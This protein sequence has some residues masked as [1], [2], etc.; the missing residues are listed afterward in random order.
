MPNFADQQ[1]EMVDLLI[2]WAEINSG[3]FNLAGLEVMKQEI[4]TKFSP[5]ADEHE[6]LPA[7][8]WK[9]FN[10]QGEVFDQKLGDAVLF[11]KRAHLPQKILFCGHMDTVFPADSSFQ[12]VT[13]VDD[14]TLNGPGVSDLK[15][16]LVML[17]HVLKEME[18]TDWGQKIG[19]EILI[20]GDEEVGSWGSQDHL[21]AA[22]GRNTIG[23]IFEPSLPD[24]S[25]VSERKGAGNFYIA[26]KGKAAHAGREHAN[27]RSAIL[28][29][30]EFVVAAEALNGTIPDLTLNV[31]LIEGGEA[32][33]AVPEH[34]TC[35]IDFR[36]A[37][38]DD[39]K[40]LEAKLQTILNELNQKD[41]ITLQ[42]LGGLKRPPKAFDE[43]TREIFSLYE[44]VGVELGIAL[45]TRATGGCCDGNNLAAAGL[46]N[47]DTLGVRGGEI[48]S[49]QEYIIL[50]SLAERAELNFRFLEEWTK[51]NT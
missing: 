4:I 9:K 40:T 37:H 47:L 5:L 12:K 42:M 14:N 19:W 31:G 20:N 30:S 43:K 6:I 2:H 48:H 45:K 10:K 21:A 17:L 22:A 50:D 38:A 18:Q 24:G 39:A 13:K 1:S 41:G 25:I 34:A 33:N 46:P 35:V 26:A 27:G 3:S 36:A 51:A 16:G 44:R 28:A 23:L 11:K 49:S 15:G 7:K 32:A 29:L 8:P